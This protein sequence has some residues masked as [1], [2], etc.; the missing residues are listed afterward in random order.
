MDWRDKPELIEG[1]MLEHVETCP[2]V[3]YLN[4]SPYGW[5][6]ETETPATDTSDE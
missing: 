1:Q 4:H 3:H 6:K 5:P 2:G